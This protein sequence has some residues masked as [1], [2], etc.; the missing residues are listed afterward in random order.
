MGMY[1]PLPKPPSIK[2]TKDVHAESYS[3]MLDSLLQESDDPSAAWYQVVA[4]MPSDEVGCV[5]IAL[6]DRASYGLGL[7]PSGGT[8]DEFNRVGLVVSDYYW[9]EEST[10]VISIV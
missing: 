5:E 6:S 2:K 4:E 7:V 1:R 9:N 10:V 8:I 3:A